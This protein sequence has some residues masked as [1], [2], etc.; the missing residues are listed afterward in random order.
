MKIPMRSM[1]ALG[2]GL[3]LLSGLGGCS[4]PV[5]PPTGWSFVMLGDTRGADN[6]T[7]G[8]S[9][10][11]PAIAQKIAT[12]HPRLVIVAGDMCNGNSLNPESPLYPANGNFSDAAA[13]TIYAREFAN[14][15]AA[16]RPVFDY[17]TGIGIPICTVR[18]NHE[19]EHMG[20]APIAVLQQAYREA[21][22]AYVPANGPPGEQ[23]LSWSL[24]RGNVTFVAADQYMHFD[25]TFAGGTTPWTGYHTLERAWVT[26][27]FQRSRAP[28]KILIAH[29]PMFQTEGNG[30]GEMYNEGGQ[31]YFGIDAAGLAARSDFWN[32]CGDAGVQLY[33]TGHLHLL[34]VAS[35]VT[36]H[37]KTVVQL[38]VGN[39]GAP[40]QPFI[41]N[42]EAGVTTLYNNGNTFANGAVV[43]TVGFS[44][45][46]VQAGQMTI[47]YYA[48]DTADNSWTVAGYTTRILPT[49]AMD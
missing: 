8:H 42:P 47:E 23:G 32:D 33:V 5:A 25:P 3:V 29:E 2:A 36:G 1:L 38:M 22:S 6:T 49:A 12:L 7:T 11:L 40:M 43:G 15:K 26:A 41:D 9:P 13:K 19:N 28:Y 10:Y 48:L 24:T 4:D 31:H 18:G 44:L 35:T 17:T 27:Q 20:G 21:F 30:A 39:G 16:M 37:G 45:A 14:W 34:T 46:T